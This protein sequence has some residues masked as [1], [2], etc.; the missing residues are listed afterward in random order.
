[1]WAAYLRFGEDNVELYRLMFASGLVPGVAED[2]ALVEAAW[3]SC[4]PLLERI[5]DGSSKRAR[6]TANA[7]WAQL[8]GFVMLKADG[9]IR[10]PI[11]ELLGAMP[12]HKTPG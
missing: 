11:E 2:S 12:A 3:A 7:I 9:F 10:E 5:G 1:M 4:Q 8:H 6:M